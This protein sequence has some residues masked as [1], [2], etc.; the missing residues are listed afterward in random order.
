MEDNKLHPI[1]SIENSIVKFLGKNLKLYLSAI[2]LSSILH[3]GSQPG[4]VYGLAK[5]HKE[6]TPLRPVV[7]MLGTA[8]YHPA[9]YPD[10]III[11]NISSM[12]ML[13]CNVS[14]IFQLNQFR[15]IPSHVLLAMLLNHCLR[16][17]LCKKQ[18]KM[19]VSMSTCKMIHQNIPLNY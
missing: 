1:T 11:E 4:K 16:T 3:S 9:K 13:D 10:S 5:V 18:L 17:Y 14:F 12:Y 19:F 15:F 7:S 2:E 6:G 8:E